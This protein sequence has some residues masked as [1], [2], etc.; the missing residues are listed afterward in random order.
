MTLIAEV[1]PKSRTEKNLVRSMPKKSSLEGSFGK[2]HGKRDQ[3][4]L[5]FAWQ[6]FY[7]F[8][9]RCEGN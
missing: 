4:L 2:Q 6:Q 7:R 3:T 1:F 5:K 8:I 9:D